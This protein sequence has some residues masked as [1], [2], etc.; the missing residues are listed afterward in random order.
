MCQIGF[1]VNSSSTITGAEGRYKAV[2]ASTWKKFPITVKSGKVPAA[3]TPDI[4]VKGD[5]NLEIRIKDSNEIWSDWKADKIKVAENCGGTTPG[6]GPNA[7][8]GKDSTILGESVVLDGSKSKALGGIK[9]YSWSQ[10]SGISVVRILKA[11]QAKATALITAK[12]TYVFNLTV[13]DNKGAK[14]N[15]TVK[16]TKL[17]NPKPGDGRPPIEPI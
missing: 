12:G 7:N 5:Y 2:S 10:E 16:V 9:S 4:T 8:A 13:T 6:P 15:D 17:P 11:N 1:T 3:K 14:D